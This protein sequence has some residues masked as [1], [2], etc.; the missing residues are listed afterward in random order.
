VKRLAGSLRSLLFVA[1]GAATGCSQVSDAGT[2]G[3]GAPAI[4]DGSARIGSDASGGSAGSGGDAGLSVATG[5]SGKKS[6]PLD[7]TWTVLFDGVERTFDVHVPGSYDPASPTALVLDFHGY[8]MSASEEAALSR[9]DDESDQAGFIAVHPNGTGAS[10]LSWNAGGCCGE[11]AATGVDD[12]GFVGALLDQLE[13]GL[14]VDE[15]RVYA[16]GMSNGGFFAHRLG[17]ELPGRIAAIAP[18]AGVLDLPSCQPTRAMPVIE[19]HGTADTV[20][21]YLGNPVESF[22]SVPDTWKGWAMR[23]GCSDAPKVTFQLGDSSCQT[24]AQCQGGAEVTLCT[25]V[26]GGHTWPGGTPVPT[27]GYTTMALSATHAMWDFFAKHPLP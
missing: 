3:G 21:P 15:K 23:G 9:M 6:Q 25:V 22:A 10:G 12:V 14:C 2:G 7:A 11:A 5:C 8:G 19:F 4:S 16:T 26:N 1:A 20:V 18:V 17:C 13:T 27:L 24:Y